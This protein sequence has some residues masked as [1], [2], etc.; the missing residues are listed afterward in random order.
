VVKVT[1]SQAIS[2]IGVGRVDDSISI[3]TSVEPVTS[4]W[5]ET[6]KEQDQF[7]VG[8]ASTVIREY[9]LLQGYVVMVYDIYLSTP[10]ILD[11]DLE[12]DMFSA[13]G[14]W[15]EVSHKVATQF[16]DLII[17]KG[18]PFFKKWRIVVANA[19]AAYDAYFSAHGITTTETEYYGTGSPSP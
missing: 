8:A 9:D 4:S 14:N 13:L 16:V 11:V 6:Y 17:S 1:N 2:T 10:S 15:V 19:G 5:Q 3:G 18:H 12:V 7:N